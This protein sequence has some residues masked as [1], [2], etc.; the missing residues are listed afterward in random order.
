MPSSSFRRLQLLALCST[1]SLSASFLGEAGLHLTASAQAAETSAENK[2]AARD[3]ALD[4]IRLAEKG[5][6]EEAIDKLERAEK[7]YHAITILTWIGKCQ[8]Q[9]GR[10]VEGTETLNRVVR[11]RLEPGAPEAYAKAQEQAKRL[12]AEAKPKIARLTIIVVDDDD[13]ELNELPELAV[14]VDDS[15]LSSALVGAAR[16]T[17]PGDHTVSVS[18]PGYES[19]SQEVSLKA[20]EAQELRIQLKAQKASPGS[21]DALEQTGDDSSSKLVPWSLI[22]G[23]GALMVGGGVTGLLALNNK[24]S[25]TCEPGEV[26]TGEDAT[27]L[28]KA[29]RQAAISTV[30]FGVGGAAAITGTVL[31][32]T[33]KKSPEAE[34]GSA[35]FRPLV[36]WGSMG[37]SGDF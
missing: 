8:L 35:R 30:L 18:A 25:L 37:V 1:F 24:N 17:D 21:P 15:P 33:G 26:C 14:R 4:G 3:L 9:T 22:A 31:L 2:A 23:G 5:Q 36:G 16:P 27:T 10:I 6:C 11:E 13:G 7:L 34:V 12:I 19:A 29:R 32:L 20:G 28:P